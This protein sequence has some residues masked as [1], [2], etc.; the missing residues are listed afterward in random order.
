MRW[1]WVLAA[2]LAGCAGGEPG[3]SV[4][5]KAPAEEPEP[6][7]EPVSLFGYAL[8][9]DA[10]T[11]PEVTWDGD[12]GTVEVD[13]VEVLLRRQDGKLTAV[14]GTTS[15]PPDSFC[16][17][18]GANLFV[19]APGEPSTRYAAAQVI[20]GCTVERGSAMLLQTC[21]PGQCTRF[22]A[23]GEGAEVL[24]G[25]VASPTV[26]QHDWKNRP[27]VGDAFDLGGHRY[28]VTGIQTG[29]RVGQK[30]SNVSASKGAAF[31]VVDYTIATLAKETSTVLAGDLV[32]RDTQG[33]T[34]RPSSNATTAYAATRGVDLLLS[35]L[36]PGIAREQAAVFEVPNDALARVDLVVPA[37]DSG[38]E[39]V[40]PLTFAKKE[41]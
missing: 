18:D 25:L 2:M 38:D 8:D 26:R 33:R 29:Q 14:G 39:V 17:S 11:G 35:E 10:P 27:H 4:P 34:F 37:K 5:A 12:K 1:S 40:I 16:S 15:T 24:R 32:L 13:G 41:A 28:Q 31:V 20:K 3:A 23:S 30:Y 7:P 9:S 19:E 22:L 36:Q 6:E 21:G